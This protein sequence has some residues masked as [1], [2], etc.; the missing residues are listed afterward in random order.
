MPDFTLAN[1]TVSPGRIGFGVLATAYLPDSTPVNVPLIVVHG[2]H[3]GPTLLLTAAMHGPEIPG[4]E[5]IRRITR[6]AVDPSNLRGTIIALPIVNPFAFSNHSMGA[7]QDGYNM[8]R[9]FPGQE[10][11]LLTH[12]LAY[13]VFHQAVPLADAII[14]LHANPTPAIM[15]SLYRNQPSEVGARAAAMAAAYGIT[16]IQMRLENEAHRSGTMGDAAQALGKPSLTIELLSWRRALE[17]SVRS[18]VRGTLN[19]M[20]HL[21]MLDGELEAQED[22]PVIPGKL[23]RVEITAE[24]GG[25]VHF[26]SDAGAAVKKGEVIARIVNPY[27][28]LMEEV[29]SPVDG[30]ILAYPLLNSQCAATGDFVNFIAYRI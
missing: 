21:G 2:E 22:V 9:V 10:N 23:S 24:K 27:G 19:V 15:F 11:G 20:K 14:D 29:A 8:N 30:W 18:G 25:L 7:P 16:T 13:Q 12:R 17:D 28:D 3:P 5:V 1:V 6:E 4:C 26:L